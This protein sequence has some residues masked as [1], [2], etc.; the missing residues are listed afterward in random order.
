[1]DPVAR[2]WDVLDVGVRE[3]PM[4]FWVIVRAGSGAKTRG[5]GEGG[6]SLEYQ[7]K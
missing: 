5:R 6:A 1:V 2:I 4:D 7:A 3:Q